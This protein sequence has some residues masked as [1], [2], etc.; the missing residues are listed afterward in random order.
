MLQCTPS[1]FILISKDHSIF[2]YVKRTCTL[3]R[4][5]YRNMMKFL[6]KPV[7]WSLVQYSLW[8]EGFFNLVYP[9]HVSSAETSHVLYVCL[10]IVF[11]ILVS[12]NDGIRGKW[13]TTGNSEQGHK[14]SHVYPLK[15]H[16]FQHL[17]FIY[18]I[19]EFSDFMRHVVSELPKNIKS[20][21]RLAS[22]NLPWDVDWSI[23]VMPLTNQLQV[24]ESFLRS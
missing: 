1:I 10:T 18:M 6:L 20:Q 16:N 15:W 4:R 19:T 5:D 24:A 13:Q 21:F 14:V 9:L 8:V 2:S 23:N 22:H 11:L 17:A 12:F 3:I 7:N